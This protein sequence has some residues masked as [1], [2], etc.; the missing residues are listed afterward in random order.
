MLQIKIYIHLENILYQKFFCKIVLAVD[1]KSATEPASHVTNI[2]GN[3]DHQSQYP[4]EVAF[5]CGYRNRYRDQESGN[6]VTDSDI[7][8]LCLKGKLDILKYCRKVRFV[9]LITIFHINVIIQ[10]NPIDSI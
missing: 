3:Q 6:W 1:L 2:G 10:M 9:Y 4:P 7:H 5:Q 8:A